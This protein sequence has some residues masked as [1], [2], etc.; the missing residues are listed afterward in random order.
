M[1]IMGLG[2]PEEDFHW[3]PC[4]LFDGSGSL[5]S[6]SPSCVALEDLSS[7][8]KRSKRAAQI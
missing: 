2:S 6:G 8:T 5:S 4:N 7:H 1:L 3:R